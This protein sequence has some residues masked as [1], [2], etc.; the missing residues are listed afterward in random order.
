M[1]RCREC[2]AFFSEPLVTYDDPSPTGVAL[3]QGKYVEYHCPNCFGEDIEEAGVCASC[4]EPTEAGSVLCEECRRELA[5]I[6]DGVAKDMKL[7]ADMLE[8]AIYELY[9]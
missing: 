8:E 9:Q 2:G 6:M 7:S 1:D 5:D 4:G 3:P